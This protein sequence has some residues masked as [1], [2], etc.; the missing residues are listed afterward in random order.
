MC[1]SDLTAQ[2]LGWKSSYGTGKG[3]D[4]ITSG[5]EVI[6]TSTPTHWGADFF[7]NLFEHEW[8]LHESPAGAK[9]WVAKDA[10]ANVPDAHDPSK[11]HRPTMLTTDLALRLD[12]A[13]EKVSRNFYEHPA[14]L[15][16]IG[17]ASCRERV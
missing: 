3:G 6:W 8:E 16:E 11:K 17:R 2:G 15:R 4:T 7:E 5:L 9:Q 1:S 14:G 10:E 12:P 13:Y